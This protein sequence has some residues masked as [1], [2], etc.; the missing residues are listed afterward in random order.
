MGPDKPPKLDYEVPDTPDAQRWSA[1][2]IA[3]WV[4]AIILLFFIVTG[5]LMW[6]GWD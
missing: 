5:V 1:S 4:I 6:L 3:G 2:D